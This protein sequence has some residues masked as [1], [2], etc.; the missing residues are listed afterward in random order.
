[1]PCTTWHGLA[2]RLA[3][4]VDS[5]YA[6][7]LTW[8]DVD[9]PIPEAQRRIE[10]EQFH[11]RLG[12]RYGGRHFRVTPA[13][14]DAVCQGIEVERIRAQKWVLDHPGAPS[15]AAPAGAATGWDQ[16][17]YDRNAFIY[18]KALDGEVWASIQA[19]VK[20]RSDWAA[21]DTIQGVKH[22]AAAFAKRTGKPPVP[23]RQAGKPTDRM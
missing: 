10:C 23:A 21:L 5:A 14:L 22:A 9:P 20:K 13:L 2:Y 4:E 12:A 15:Y 16:A 6:E 19:M 11:D 8:D 1:M 17:T 3:V 7:L 18:E